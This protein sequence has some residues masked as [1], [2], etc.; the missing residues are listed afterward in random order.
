MWVGDSADQ[1][2]TKLPVPLNTFS[3][4]IIN[5]THFD[6]IRKKKSDAAID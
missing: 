2:L 1:E 3:T 4:D 5:Y 6:Y